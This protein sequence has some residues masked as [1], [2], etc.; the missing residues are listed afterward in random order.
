MPRRA[1]FQFALFF[2]GLLIGFPALFPAVLNAQPGITLHQAVVLALEH[3]PELAAANLRTQ[4]SAE[5]RRQAGLLPNPRFIFQA[6]NLRGG[7]YNY[8][9]QS[10]TYAYF[11]QVIETSG[12]RGTRIALADSNRQRASTDRDL[13]RRD[14]MYSVAEA[15]WNAVTTRQ[16]RDLYR[17]D[18]AYFD[19]IV[20][21]H[22]ARLRE[23]KIAEVDLLRVQLESE[24]LRA[25][26]ELAGADYIRAEMQLARDMGMPEAG[27]LQLVENFDE[28]EQPVV[29]ETPG[30]ALS[31]RV[32]ARSSEEAVQTARAN[33]GVQRAMGRPDLDLVAG[34]KRTSGM[35]TAL[36]GF[37]L[38]LPLFDRNQG[39]TAAARLEERAAEQQ[40][41]AVK[42][43]LT[44]EIALADKL[45]QFR[46]QQIVSRYR[47]LRDRAVEI[48]T[49]SRA[50][51][52]EGGT[53]LLRLLDAER[54]RT[55]TQLAYVLALRDYHQSFVQVQRAQGAEL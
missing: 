54:L 47:P 11:S 36:A 30:A 10:D 25:A 46:R 9:Q 8:S 53:D 1:V 18:A 52:R 45:Y 43:Q 37:Q 29:S 40:L 4:A 55:E 15:Y 28:L 32:E 38:N 7:N 17:E 44:S 35:N 42:L 41:A 3:R 34:Y 12:R 33:L 51:Y 16:V 6:E 14:V 13:M 2:I 31:R 19:Q 20:Q 39:A 24:R 23:G 48:S 26:A 50:A 49:V 22:Q 5:L 27:V 21:Y